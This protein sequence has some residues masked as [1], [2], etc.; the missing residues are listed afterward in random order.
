MSSLGQSTGRGRRAGSEDQKHSSGGV[1]VAVDSNLGAVI[2]E[3]EGAV[4]SIPGNEGR[5][6]QVW[7]N[8]RGGC[9]CLQITNGTRRVGL[10]EMKLSWT[11]CWKEPEPQSIRG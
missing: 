7:V 3:K 1:F 11:R 6:A 5:V 9:E 8:V 2:G 4:M 10:Q